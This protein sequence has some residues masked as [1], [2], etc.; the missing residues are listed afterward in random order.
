MNRRLLIH[1]LIFA[2]LIMI[3]VATLFTGCG[4]Q[5]LEVD[6]RTFA[7]DWMPVETDHFVFYVP[8]DS[9][10]ASRSLMAFGSVCE[11]VY[12]QVVRYLEIE[13]PEPIHIYQ[14]TTNQDCEET[15]GH[16][17]NFVEAYNI[18]TRIGAEIGGAVALAM[19]HAID[20]EAKSFPLIKDGLR[21]VFDERQVN[22]HREASTLLT[23]SG[24]W[25]TL[26]ELIAGH[27]GGDEKV[28][29]YATASFVA[30]LIQRHGHERLKMLW[31]SVLELGP[32]LERIYG[33]PL[34]QLES[35]WMSHMAQEAKRT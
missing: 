33:V 13:V 32:S 34:D 4:G 11:D 12:E 1:L 27:T 15:I 23:Q 7:R 28:Y 16:P 31:R 20:P 29:R 17:A 8:P 30:F 21:T 24:R 14:F 19:C 3:P 6:P 10:R 22:V 2:A 25:F 18:Y 26:P 9:P 35:E 5:K